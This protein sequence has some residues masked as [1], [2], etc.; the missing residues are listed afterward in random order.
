MKLKYI[1][2]PNLTKTRQSTKLLVQEI[3]ANAEVGRWVVIKSTKG[4]TPKEYRAAYARVKSGRKRYP[5]LM[6][7][8]HTSKKNYTVIA[9]KQS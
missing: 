8:I 9:Q 3:I 7:S 6:W 5:A 1:N 2:N 4:K